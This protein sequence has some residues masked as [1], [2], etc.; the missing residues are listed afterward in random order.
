MRN[1]KEVRKFMD[2]F[3]KEIQEHD[4][5]AEA[6]EHTETIWEMEFG[7]KFYK[8]YESFRAAKSHFNK[9][10]KNLKVRC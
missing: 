10:S 5:M 6:Y 7:K 3:S 9:F 1:H 2:W 4:T 8:N